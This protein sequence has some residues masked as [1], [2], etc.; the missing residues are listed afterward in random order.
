MNGSSTLALLDTADAAV[1]G[2][3]FYLETD[4]GEYLVVVTGEN[5]LQTLHL[6]FGGPV[7]T[8]DR[9]VLV[10]GEE[11]TFSCPGSAPHQRRLL[12]IREDTL[13]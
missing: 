1:A 10:P 11:F 7:G 4:L 3:R 6:P 12:S 13:A 9:Q 8:L 5:Q 2:K